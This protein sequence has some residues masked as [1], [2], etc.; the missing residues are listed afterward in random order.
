MI[1]KNE[2][3]FT[4]IVT[5][6]S[7]HHYIH[8]YHYHNGRGHHTQDESRCNFRS[9]R[10]TKMNQ[11]YNESLIKKTKKQLF[12]NCHLFIITCKLMMYKHSFLS[13]PFSSAENFIFICLIRTIWDTITYISLQNTLPAIADKTV[14]KVASGISVQIKAM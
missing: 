9:L 1:T 6:L 5:I 13:L 4:I 7:R 8:Q 2:T 3:F 11:F 14:I 10:H 12:R